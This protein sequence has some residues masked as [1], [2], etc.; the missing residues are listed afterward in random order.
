[1]EIA[2]KALCFLVL[3]LEI[4]KNENGMKKKKHT[5]LKKKKM[6]IFI[7]HPYSPW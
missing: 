7:L 4:K 1:M 3:A 2:E 5:L 6:V